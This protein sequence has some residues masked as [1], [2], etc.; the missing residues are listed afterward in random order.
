[1][2]LNEDFSSTDFEKRFTIVTGMNLDKLLY[3]NYVSKFL[4]IF[5]Q[6]ST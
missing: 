3:F 2:G 6:L 1:M 4:T 5:D